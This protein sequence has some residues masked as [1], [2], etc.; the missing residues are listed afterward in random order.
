M[1]VRTASIAVDPGSGRGGARAFPVAWLEAWRDGWADVLSPGVDRD[2]RRA[3]EAPR[4]AADAL[5]VVLARP[6]IGRRPA[7][8]ARRAWDAPGADALAALRREL[9]LREDAPLCLAVETAFVGALAIPRRARDAAPAILAEHIAARTPLDPDG[10]VLAHAVRDAPG[11][12]ARLAFI[13]VP[14]ERRDALLDRLGL[15]P[16]AIAF[17]EA[18]GPDGAPCRLPL[19]PRPARGPA[20]ARLLGALVLAA[21]LTA[22]GL[23]AGL[24]WRQAQALADAQ[25]RADALVET[26]RAAAADARAPLALAEDVAAIEAARALP[27]VALIEDLAARVPDDAYLTGLEIGAESLAMTALSEDAPGLVAALE[28]SAHL[29]DAAPTSALVR[30]G[31]SGRLRVSIGARLASPRALPD[32]PGAEGPR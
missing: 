5:G 17:L 27:V 7:A 26:A 25:A 30:D 32:A 28:A 22:A 15:A 16:E 11:G 8:E 13:A 1:A 10:L 19:A 4:L 20:R 12:R 23:F 24:A 21:A 14:R 2:E 31:A 29:E 6:A 3:R 9:G 18:A